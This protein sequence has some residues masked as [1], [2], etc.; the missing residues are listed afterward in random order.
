MNPISAFFTEHL[1][2][3]FFFYGLA[4]FVLGLALSFASRQTSEFRF[5]QAI[6]PLAVFGL[7][8]GIHE[9]VEMFQMIAPQ[10]GSDLSLPWINGIRL[11]LLAVSFLTLLVFGIVLLSP[12]GTPAPH[13][14]APVAMMVGVWAGAVWLVG[15]MLNPP[16]AELITLADVLARYLFGI[17]GA[18]VGTWALMVQQKTFRE[19]AM[20]QFG[21]DLVWCAA[22]LFLYGVI[23]QVF[24]HPTPLVPSTIF[25][26]QIFLQWFGVPVQLFRGALAIFFTFFMLRALRAFELENQ[27]RLERANQAK[28]D[29]QAAALAAERR[30]SHETERLNEELQMAVHELTLLLDLARLLVEPMDL[31]E[32]LQLVAERIVQSI[33]YANAALIILRHSQDASPYVAVARG[34]AADPPDPRYELAEELGHKCIASNLALCRHMD[35]AVIEFTLEDAL[36]KQDCRKQQSATMM[37][38]LPLVAQ[39]KNIGCVVLAA[40]VGRERLITVD[41]FALMIGIG[42]QVGLSIENARLYQD[43]QKREKTLADLLHQVVGAQEAERRRIARELHDATGQS[44][45]AISLGLRGIEALLANDLPVSARQ[46]RDLQTF[47]T[48]AIGELRRIIADLRPSQLDDLGLVAALRWYVSAFEKRRGITCEFVIDGDP[49]R[50]SS[51]YETVLFRIVQEAFTNVAKHS[52]A[53]KVTVSLDTYPHNIILNIEDNGK[54]FDAKAMLSGENEYAGWGLMGIRERVLLLGGNYNIESSPGHG[55]EISICVPLTT[56]DQSVENKITA[57]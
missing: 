55:T 39:N 18:L 49:G 46:I 28:L 40:P 51:E 23:G 34:F 3:V 8:H 24:V 43:V 53:S 15:A 48:E 29:A 26:S 57:G 56:E 38:A 37:I 14:Y 42:Q 6:K 21:R 52:G 1:I 30:I 44:L 11:V 45:T 47:G 4:F 54:G 36:Q 13:K 50:L 17:P 35:G 12:K 41:E 27:Q 2:F 32:R 25:N 19:R 9:W 33:K 16:I 5:V 7:L 31:R 10:T 20:P 22:A